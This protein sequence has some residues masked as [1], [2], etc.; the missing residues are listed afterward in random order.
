MNR[1]PSLTFLL[2]AVAFSLVSYFAE[3][4]EARTY[5]NIIRP[6]VSA[7]AA[8]MG[9]VRYSTGL[10]DENFFANPARTGDNPYWRLDIVNVLVELNSGSISNVSKLTKGG[11]KIENL[12]S[13]AGTNNHVRIQT[14]IPAFYSP[15]FF[16]DR[17]ALAIGLVQSTQADIGLRKNMSLEPDVFMDIGPA[18]SFSRKFMKDDRL[19]VGVTAHYTYRAATR[20]TFS[21]ID[22]IKGTSFKSVK[23]IAGEGNK[24]DFD[25]GARHNVAWSPKDW[26]LQTAF[27][28]NN[29]LGSSYKEGL[30]L[31]SGVQAVPVKQPRTVNA[32]VS[33]SKDGA[34]GFSGATFA[35]EVQDVGN[36]SGGS[37]FRTLH[38][39]GELHARRIL[40]LRAGI[41]QGY[42]SGG[43]GLDFPLLKIDFTTYG[44]E[45]S[46]NA[47]GMEDRRYAVRLGLQ[48]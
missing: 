1:K 48:I 42:L 26:K 45:M 46:L 3:N 17:N 21:T 20:E 31:I 13:T 36:N 34:F 2:A 15:H 18:V 35:F 47:G 30:D 32:G 25:L 28:I 40:F 8:A 12:A 10:F 6:Y 14:V 4:A 16:S 24:V 38:L 7:R 5:D 9:G 43:V 44:E 27:A 41:N 19:A 23:D 37:L 39:G 29:F 22:Y 11:D 33:A